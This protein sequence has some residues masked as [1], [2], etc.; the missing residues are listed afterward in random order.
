MVTW[1]RSETR[2]NQPVLHRLLRPRK[3][4]LDDRYHISGQAVVTLNGKKFYRGEHD[5]PDSHDLV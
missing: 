4:Q 2:L 3:T 1:L 5:S